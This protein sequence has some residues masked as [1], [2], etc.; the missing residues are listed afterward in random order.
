MREATIVGKDSGMKAWR[1]GRN[2][3]DSF[4][5][6][7]PVPELPTGRGIQHIFAYHGLVIK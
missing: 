7:Q 1:L 3:T 6:Q 5:F 2:K 4:V